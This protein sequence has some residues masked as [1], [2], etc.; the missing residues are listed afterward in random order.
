MLTRALTVLVW[1]QEPGSES[2]SLMWPTNP[3]PW[4]IPGASEC[5]VAGSWSPK[6]E[7]RIHSG[8][9]DIGCAFLPAR[10]PCCISCIKKKFSAF[11]IYLVMIFWGDINSF[12]TVSVIVLPLESDWSSAVKQPCLYGRFR[13]SVSSLLLCSRWGDQEA[14]TLE[15]GLVGEKEA[16]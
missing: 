8:H 1:S 7:L 16:L 14:W 3:V 6:L 2:T 5:A 4:A 13:R 12:I 11:L 15:R 9:S 10:L